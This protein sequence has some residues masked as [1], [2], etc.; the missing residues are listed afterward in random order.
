M[1]E[2]ATLMQKST[3]GLGD[4]EV[5]VTSRVFLEPE[6]LI[7]TEV[8]HD[9]ALVTKSHVPIPR[10][11]AVRDTAPN[12]SALAS[13]LRAHHLRFVHGLIGGDV[14]APP[15]SLQPS[16]YV[17]GTLGRLRLGPHGEVLERDGE[18]QV[19]WTWLRTAYLAVGAFDD[20][21]YGAIDRATFRC[22]TLSAVLSRDGASTRAV[23]F[24]PNSP[25]PVL[26]IAPHELP[27][28]ELDDAVRGVATL[29]QAGTFVTGD[30]GD[31]A[32]RN[33][34]ERFHLVSGGAAPSVTMLDLSYESCLVLVA[35][36]GGGSVVVV[37]SPRMTPM[38]AAV[39]L[40]APRRR[41]STPGLPPDH[42]AMR[43]VV[44]AVVSETVK[45]AKHGLG[46]AVIR[47]YMRHAQKEAEPY[48]GWVPALSV[49]IDGRVSI[50]PTPKPPTPREYALGLRRLLAHFADRARS[51]A[52][53]L[54][55][56]ELSRTL[57]SLGPD[58]AARSL[59]SALEEP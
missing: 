34:Q 54:V 6:P 21:G 52:P 18:D 36:I 27:R 40:G 59:R 7:L 4:K 13:T 1:A 23:F 26:S 12:T 32:A 16:A 53:D 22:A 43:E 3:V 55:L 28:L 5:L 58:P 56:P 50:G 45:A 42:D 31:V 19:P 29:T 33:V 41:S 39:R 37:G 25:P 30:M 51:V 24:E 2:L 49:A 17:A 57:E 47:N 48:D 11:E 8:T 46:F 20:L 35:S 38:D 14:T 15:S 10:A 44:V 9:G